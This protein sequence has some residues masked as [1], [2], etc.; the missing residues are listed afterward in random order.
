MNLES[1]VSNLSYQDAKAHGIR[2]FPVPPARIRS[3]TFSPTKNF[4][5]PPF[6]SDLAVAR[7]LLRGIFENQFHLFQCVS[8]IL[9]D[10]NQAIAMIRLNCLQQWTLG[11][12]SAPVNSFRH[13]ATQVSHRINAVSLQH[14]A[15]KL[16]ASL[17]FTIDVNEKSVNIDI[18][19]YFRYTDLFPLVVPVVKIMVTV[20]GFFKIVVNRQN[21]YYILCLDKIK[22]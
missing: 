5:R 15:F 1:E 17:A 14:V 2:V 13:G 18:N 20:H 4:Q 9:F 8:L 3:P 11:E 6:F 7:R 16:Y 21:T 22:K 10:L 19:A 12:N